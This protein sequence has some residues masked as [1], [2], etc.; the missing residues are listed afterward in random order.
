VHIGGVCRSNA[1]CQVDSSCVK[2]HGTPRCW[3][4]CTS[5]GKCFATFICVTADDK[6]R[7]CTW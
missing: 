5:A 1:E 3:P 2:V 6:Q 4:P 7:V